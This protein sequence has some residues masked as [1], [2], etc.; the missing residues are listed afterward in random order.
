M[1]IKKILLSQAIACSTLVLAGAAYAQLEEVIVTAQKHAQ[2]VN[3]IGITVNAFTGEQLRDIGVSSAEDIAIY[4][5]GLT[6]NE[7]AATGVP[8]YTIRGVGFQDYSTAASSTVGLY[9]DEVAIPYTVMS[10]GVV[11]DVERVE[12]LKGPQGDLYGRNTTAGQIN[13]ISNKPSDE[14]EAGFSLGYDSLDVLDIEGYVSGSLAESVNGRLAVKSSKSNQGWQKSLTRN[15][16]LGE[17]DQLALRSILDFTLNDEASLLL[18]FHY[19]KDKSDN[20][21]NTAYDGRIAGLNQFAAPYRQLADYVLPGGAK[22]GQ[23]P[24]WYSTGDNEAADW[25]NSYT[26]ALTGKTW[27]IRPRRDNELRGLSAKLEWNF[28]NL[29]LTSISSYDEFEREEANDWDGTAAIDSSNINNTELEV[30]SQELRISGDSESLLWIAGV[31]YSRDEMDEQYHYF[32]AD[33]VFGNGSIPFGVAPFNAASIL[34]LDTKYKQETESQAVF[35][36]VEWQATEQLRLTAGLRYTREQR[37]WS[38]CTYDAGDGSLANFLNTS[39]GA[40]LQPGD[41]GTIDDD[42]NSANY[43]FN[44]IGTANINNAFPVFSDTIKTNRWMG[45]L[46][47]DYAFNDDILLYATLSQGFKSGGFNGAN[48]NAT[49][50]LKPYGAEKLTSFETGVK[51]TLLENTMQLN[52]A[53][54]W[55]DYKD[56]QEQDTAVAFVGNIS[57]LTNVPESRIN[58]FEADMQWLP[59]EQL[60]LNLGLAYL[61]TEIERWMAVDTAASAWPNVVRRDASGIEL[62]QS[63]KWSYNALAKYEWSIAEDLILEVAADVVF[64]DDTSGGVTAED[65]TE[66]YTIVNARIAIGSEDG[67]WRALLWGRNITDEYY[68]PAA[69]RGGNGPFVRSAGLP[70]TYGLTL[71]YNF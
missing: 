3:D 11:F 32:M 50:Q 10:R 71:S 56:K 34:E 42:P 22:F 51:T 35:A 14:F 12:V 29:S 15:D 48:S 19:V 61:D 21:A 54:F 59:T 24:E 36:H 67:R 23:T 43:I 65:A 39:F 7:T 16:E 31:Y 40:T 33:S 47:A 30:F 53:A 2:G 62:A 70:R 52:M 69:Y 41:C 46:G 5:P 68:Y 37:D 66:D 1:K 25:S 26:S 63:P 18:N 8:L 6:V 55:Y 17:K 60:T 28:E 45:K 49:Q 4:T 13:F 27:N 20:K 38:G 44:V 9:F 57:G 64:Q 58:G